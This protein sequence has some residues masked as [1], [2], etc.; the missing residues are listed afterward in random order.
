MP[1][2]KPTITTD[3][4]DEYNVLKGSSITL[5]IVAEGASSYQWWDAIGEIDGATSSSYTVEGGNT[6]GA[7]QFYFCRVTNAAGYTDSNNT[8]VTM[9]R[10][11]SISNYGWVF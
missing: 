3:L 9:I 1:A 4:E 11:S 2:S 8:K 5:S 6:I 7:V 10:T